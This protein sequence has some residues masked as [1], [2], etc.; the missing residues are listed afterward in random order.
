MNRILLLGVETRNPL[1]SGTLNP[2]TYAGISEQSSTRTG[3]SNTFEREITLV[4]I[5]WIQDEKT[6]TATGQRTQKNRYPSLI[7]SFRC[8]RLYPLGHK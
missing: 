1:R 4:R 6:K 2:V 5:G 8:A 3:R 7:S